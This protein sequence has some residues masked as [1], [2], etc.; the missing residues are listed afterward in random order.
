MHFARSFHSH[1]PQHI[2]AYIYSSVLAL[3]HAN[4]S[5]QRCESAERLIRLLQQKTTC[6][7]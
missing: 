1:L 6:G 3:S 2:A 7:V 4:A 5:P